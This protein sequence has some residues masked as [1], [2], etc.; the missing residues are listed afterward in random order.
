MRCSS[1]M[2]AAYPDLQEHFERVRQILL[3]EEQRF[4]RT[5]T[6]G[7]EEI[8]GTYWRTYWPT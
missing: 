1:N 8:C 3:G 6:V 5:I 4:S 2:G 7:L